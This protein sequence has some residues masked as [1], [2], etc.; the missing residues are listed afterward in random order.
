APAVLGH[1]KREHVGL[2]AG[3]GQQPTV[4]GDH[5]IVV[6]DDVIPAGR[7]RGHLGGEQFRRPRLRP[8]Q[9]LFH[10]GHRV[11]VVSA[12][13]PRPRA[14]G[15]TARDPAGVPPSTL[16][17]VPG[18]RASGRRRYMGSGGASCSPAASRPAHHS[19]AGAALGDRGGRASPGNSG[20]R[21]APS[22]APGRA[23]PDAAG[24]ATAGADSRAPSAAYRAQYSSRRR[25]SVATRNS[26]PAAAGTAS[27][28]ITSRVQ[29]PCAPTPSALPSTRAVTR[30]TR[31][32]V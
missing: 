8:E 24:A 22:P 4:P 2:A 31:S 7:V 5:P 16:L 23:P 12:H 29:Y 20:Y 18:A 32:P 19:A 27:A 26:R 15:A 13:R 28:A 14:P 17:G 11:N 21:G 25:A 10:G 30:P 3:L 6:G 9:R 1:R